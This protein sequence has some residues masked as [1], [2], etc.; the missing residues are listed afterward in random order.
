MTLA[1]LL[2]LAAGAVADTPEQLLFEANS[3]YD[4]GDY[5]TAAA[6]YEALVATEI[7]NG[8]VYYNLGNAL[9]R[10]GRL[11][12]AIATYRKARSLQPRDSDIRANLAYARD[13]TKDALKPHDPSAVL[14]T[15]F[16]WHF[17]LSE[18]ELLLLL[19][20]INLVFWG[21][22]A[23]H[24]A[25]RS[26]E[27]LRW[28]VVLLF[29]VVLVTGTSFAVRTVRPDRI[30]VINNYEVDVRSGI[31]RDTVVRFKL[32]E[33]TEAEA[34]DVEGDWVRIALP[35]GKQGWVER[36]EVLLVTL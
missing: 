30:A 10:Q 25:R 22:L 36:S 33:G 7:N 24:Q 28:A 32:H 17:S 11:G 13:A 26:S 19:V 16:F 20:I 18:R 5:V 31:S 15:L 35:D 9:L 12:H 8:Y 4:A 1:T 2:L 6:K 23:V 14:R 29:L 3:A 21:A 34:L 27:L